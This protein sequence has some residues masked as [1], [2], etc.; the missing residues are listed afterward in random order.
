MIR[1]KLIDLVTLVKELLSMAV[2]SFSM[3]IMRGN[4]RGISHT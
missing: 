1:M 3:R 4:A 2:N